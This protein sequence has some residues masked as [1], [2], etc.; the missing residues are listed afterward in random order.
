MRAFIAL[1]LPEGFRRDAAA[2][3]R[4][5]SAQ[6]E[7]RFPAPETYHMT[8]AFLGE[9][10]DAE[11]ARAHDAVDA[12]C[13]G[14]APIPLHA[15][16]L[17]TFGKPRDATLWLGL[18]ENDALVQLAASLR[19]GLAAR[20]V[21]FDTKPFKAHVTIARRARIPRGALP[22][23]PFPADAEAHAVTLF[24]SELSPQG[25]AYKPLYT[26]ILES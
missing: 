7:G 12:A 6:V 18:R 9:V 1:E 5:L 23:L 11:K 20:D 16:G 14:V 24:K 8:L 21:S 26:R 25:A 10:D 3:A 4:V 2:L 22:A 13:A 15:A 19:A 17:G